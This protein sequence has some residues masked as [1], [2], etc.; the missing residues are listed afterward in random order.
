MSGEGSTASNVQVA[1]ST[2]N[3]EGEGQEL[4]PTLTAQ[5]T[6]FMRTCTGF[7]EAYQ[8]RQLTRR[9]VVNEMFKEVFNANLTLEVG[10]VVCDQILEQL[11][12]ADAVMHHKCITEE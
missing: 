9:Q 10:Q 7:V 6:Q 5:Q 2:A 12:Q 4:P 1:P 8:R 11:N 3:T